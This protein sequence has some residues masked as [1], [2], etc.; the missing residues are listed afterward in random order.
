MSEFHV[1]DHNSRHT[2]LLALVATAMLL[3]CATPPRTAPPAKPVLMT[4]PFEQASWSQV[5]GWSDDRVQEAWTAFL[6][7]CRA[8]RFR[9]EWSA[10]CTAA[11][12]V[13]PSDGAIRQYFE[14]YF[15]PYLILK[16]GSSTRDDLGLITGYY[17][18]Q[19]K[20]ARTPSAGFKT[21]LYA[22]PPDLLTVDLASLFP[23]LKG[24]RV[25]GRLDGNRVVPYYNRA[26]LPSDPLVQGRE[27]VWVSDPLDA[28]QLEI[29]GSGRIQL[30]SGEVIRLQYADQ[31]GQPYRSIG[32]YL[33]DQRLLNVEQA[34]M[35][36]IRAWLAANPQRMQEVLNANPSVVFFNEVPIGDPS[37]GPK[38]AQGLPLTAGRSIAVDPSFIP[39]GTPV[40]LATTEPGSDAPLQRLVLAQD[41]GG[42]ING[43]PRADFFWGTG[44]E[45]GEL[46]GK[47]RQQGRM[48]L[49][50][51]KGTPLPKSQ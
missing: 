10:P 48:W 33:V 41:T 16:A 47:M 17:E 23:E 45:A 6:S 1:T 4:Q 11:N 25:R 19:L 40:F 50:W 51:P 29:Q 13:D 34:T 31:N 3:G 26:E 5:T 37:I 43:A 24:K 22:P 18:P 9:S 21:P 2:F 30:P 49:L 15:D 42:A 20:A 44:P 35:P 8:L 39:L 7:S 46:A 14:Q 38:G 12:A 28:F 27:L 32:R 36:G